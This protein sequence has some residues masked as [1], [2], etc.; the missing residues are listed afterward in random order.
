MQLKLEMNKA[1]V[2]WTFTSLIM[3]FL[4]SSCKKK[5]QDNYHPKYTAEYLSKQLET[6]YKE[7]D[8]AR[9]DCFL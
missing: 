4:F 1:L 6:A 9:L 8:S 2:K 7:N 3:V 5:V